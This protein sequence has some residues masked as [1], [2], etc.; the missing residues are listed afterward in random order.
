MKE[1]AFSLF[2]ILLVVLVLLAGYYIFTQVIAPSPKV[3][4]Y[5]GTFFASD[6]GQSQGGF[7]Y[8]ASWN[9]SMNIVG[10]TGV[11]NLSL[12]VGLGDPLKQ[13][14]FKVTEFK[15]N[16]VDNISFMLD[17]YRITMVNVTYD[18]IWNGSFDNYYAAAWG[19]DAPASEHIGTISP[20][21][22][23]GLVNTWYVELR[24]R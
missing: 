21:A 18:E 16:S 3:R 8:T 19:G 1:E 9:A 22:F 13:H 12:N 11:L 4:E 5:A 17:S 2:L 7:E 20:S 10:T 15:S 6:A 23:P 14:S 24:L